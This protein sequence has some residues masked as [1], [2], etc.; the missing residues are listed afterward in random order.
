MG[1]SIIKNQGQ[2]TVKTG[3]GNVL[4]SNNPIILPQ[5][6]CL[7]ISDHGNTDISGLTGGDIE[8]IKFSPF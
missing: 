8:L 7:K 5:G 2:L 4:P 3:G 6:K 1:L